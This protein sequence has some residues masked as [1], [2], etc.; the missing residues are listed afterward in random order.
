MSLS[1]G[2][3]TG[4]MPSFGDDD[5]VDINSI[6]YPAKV[7][8][9]FRVLPPAL[10][11]T[12]SSD[13]Y[14]T[15]SQSSD[16]PP[17]SPDSS[18]D[19]MDGSHADLPSTS[20][21]SS[22]DRRAI[23][24]RLRDPDWVPRPRNAF[25]IFRCEYSRKHARDPSDP[26][27]RSSRCDKTLSKRAGEEW[28]RLSAAEREQY[29]VLAEQEKVTHARQNPDYRFKPMRRPPPVCSGVPFRHGPAQRP[30]RSATSPTRDT[31]HEGDASLG[32]AGVQPASSPASS[33]SGRR[34]S[35]S[36]PQPV[37]TWKTVT[38]PIKPETPAPVSC[39]SS[40]ESASVDFDMFSGSEIDDSPLYTPD[41]P[42][43]PE[44]HSLP[45]GMQMLPL[46]E[47][48]DESLE[49][50][51]AVNDNQN[52]PAP[53][54]ASSGDYVYTDPCSNV[55]QQF[56][57]A[58]IDLYHASLDMTVPYTDWAC[59]APT[60]SY[61]PAVRMLRSDAPSDTLCLQHTPSA[62]DETPAALWGAGYPQSAN[63]STMFDSTLTAAFPEVLATTGYDVVSTQAGLDEFMNVL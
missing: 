50:A 3:V 29:K 41:L 32:S 1:E 42:T 16:Y 59:G 25:I 48:P 21:L 55:H 37:A 53:L 31:G 9:D 60:E 38:P 33:V 46:P 56:S 54:G 34:R 39:I 10:S 57:F 11:R 47:G 30:E 20:S 63:G 8:D 61:T 28:R 35:S 18:F 17:S 19:H 2:L 7:S 51:L 62:L 23:R 43:S 44:V 40:P 49:R 15:Y 4:W 45:C 14:S 52:S 6:T 22:S 13:S 27:D 5:D 36:M 58:D 12:S 24:N 26:S